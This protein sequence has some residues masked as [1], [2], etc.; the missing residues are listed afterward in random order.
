[1]ARDMTIPIPPRTPTPPSEEDDHVQADALGLR[2]ETHDAYSP[3]RSQYGRDDMLSPMSNTFAGSRQSPAFVTSPS[4]PPSL[5]SP[6]ALGS[7]AAL[8]DQ[9]LSPRRKSAITDVD[10]SQ[11]NG[12]ENR[13]GPFGFQTVQYTVGKPPPGKSVCSIAE[14]SSVTRRESVVM[15]R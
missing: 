4:F 3:G 1:M 6:R 9:R 14:Q 2:P 13:S 12:I 15:S 11:A 7:P 8:V 10:G 5:S